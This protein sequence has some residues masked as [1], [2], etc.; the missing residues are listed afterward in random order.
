MDQFQKLVDIIDRNSTR[1][2]EGD[3]AEICN[4]LRNIHEQV[5]PPHFLLDQ[6]KPMTLP[7]SNVIFETIRR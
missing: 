5:R 6:N 4:I 2:P 7:P 3:Y 1:L